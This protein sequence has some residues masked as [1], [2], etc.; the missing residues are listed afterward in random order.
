MKILT[1]LFLVCSI[2]LISSAQ[3]SYSGS[4]AIVSTEFIYNKGDVSFPSCHA[5]TI[6]ETDNGLIAAWFGGTAEKNPDV[7]IWVSRYSDGKWTIPVEV[8]NGIQHKD[9]R[10]PTWNPVLFNTGTE[11][12]LFYKVGPNCSDWWGEVVSSVDNGKTWINKHRL[13]EG[14]WGPIKNKPVLL[15]NGDLL[16]PSSTEIDGWRVHMER[17]SDM[18]ETWERT[19]ALNGKK[20]GAIQ[21]TILVHNDGKL[22][23]LNRSI[24]KKIFTSWSTDNGKTWSKFESSQ[25]PNPN[26]GIDA[27]T[28]KS[29]L[30]L[31]VYNHINSTGKW[32]ARNVLNIAISKDGINWEAAVLL[33]NDS[34]SDS[35]YSYPAVI[36]TSDGM[37]HITYTWNRE[38]I[39]HVVVDPS[40]LEPKPIVNGVWP[41]N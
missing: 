31:L 17:T 5:S 8:A 32:G 12:K 13:P 7:G 34:N 2:S 18:G 35:E 20:Q 28:L 11:I 1:I 19:G 9:L 25:L 6:A 14:I 38:L 36:Q 3:G 4:N 24:G 16:C 23:I 30:Q 26:S 37:V 22:Q 39:K 29:G 10:Y 40:K 21:P 33:E 41:T 27:V 15:S